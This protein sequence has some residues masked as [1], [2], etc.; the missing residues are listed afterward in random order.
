[1]RFRML[2]AF[3]RKKICGTIF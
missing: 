2:F 3:I 1:M